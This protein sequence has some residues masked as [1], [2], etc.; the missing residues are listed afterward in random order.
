MSV[1]AISDLHLPI[2]VEKPMDIFG[3]KWENYV[4]KIKDNWINTV[5]EK[6]YVI[7]SGD[8]SWATYLNEA[9]ADLKFI[10]ELPGTKIISRGNH[11]Y[12]W[13]TIKKM[14]ALKTE[15]KLDT[16]NFLQNDS[17]I[18]GKTGIAGCRG[19]ITPEDKKYTKDDEKIYKRE[20]I[21]LEMSINDAIK[22]GAERIVLSIHYPPLGE[23]Y[24]II[25]KYKIDIAV[26]GHLH[27]EVMGSYDEISPRT[28][29]VSCD[30]LSFL[31]EKIII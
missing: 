29:L 26:Y 6:D 20:L 28:K 14:N 5:C 21:R 11:D 22:K 1:Y 31:P 2:G 24:D 17:Y 19:W 25:E 12:W 18:I 13:T 4:E 3:R 10:N 23:F 9:V 30:Y 16:L 8:I 15:L 7:I 27:N